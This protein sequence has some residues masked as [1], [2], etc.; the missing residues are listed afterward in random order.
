MERD[1]K[2]AFFRK[3][4]KSISLEPDLLPFLNDTYTDFS[5]RLASE[6]FSLTELEQIYVSISNYSS[7]TYQNL[8]IA[9][10]LCGG[11]S[12]ASYTID[13]DASQIMEILSSSN[14][15][16]WQG[17]IE[18]IKSKNI[19]KNDFFEKKRSYFTE[20]MVTRF[21]RDNLTSILF[22][23]PNYSAAINQIAIL[24]SP[25]D[26][27]LESI[28]QGKS[29]CRSSWAC[30]E[31]EKALSLPVGRLDQRSRNAF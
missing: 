25:F 14:E 26:D 22:T 10:R 15:A 4:N 16:Q 9:L 28:Q 19:V 5:L 1:V 31:I 20:S 23:A 17:L 8:V 11:I 27:V 3:I 12:E 18:A 13:I 29:H 2:L 7:S 21:R 6:D 24:L 30:R